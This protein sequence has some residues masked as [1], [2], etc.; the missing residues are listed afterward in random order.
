VHFVESQ[1]YDIKG[2][3]VGVLAASIATL[4][5]A[6]SAAGLIAARRAASIDPAHALR[7]E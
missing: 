1:L 5:S 2:I 6:A 3:D 4:V 7:A